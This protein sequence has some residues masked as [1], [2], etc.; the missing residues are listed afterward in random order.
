[1]G[2]RSNGQVVGAFQS[3]TSI[4]AAMPIAAEQARATL[5]SR[6]GHLVRATRAAHRAVRLEN[7]RDGLFFYL[8]AAI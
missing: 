7:S 6:P 1:M 5:A 3:A 4:S 2:V 8:T